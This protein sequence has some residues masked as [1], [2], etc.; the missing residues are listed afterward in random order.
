MKDIHYKL[1]LYGKNLYSS[2][3]YTCDYMQ[4]NTI[5]LISS[6]GNHVEFHT[7]PI[8]CIHPSN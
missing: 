1:V 2:H 8:E 3:G 5:Q 7:I 6:S 4:N